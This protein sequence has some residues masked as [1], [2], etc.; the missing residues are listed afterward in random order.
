MIELVFATLQDDS[1]SFPVREH[2]IIGKHVC[3]VGAEACTIRVVDMAIGDD[4]AIIVAVSHGG[5]DLY[6][7]GATHDEGMIDP[8]ARAFRG[9]IY[10]SPLVIYMFV[11]ALI[12]FP[13]LSIINPLVGQC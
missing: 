11:R 9:Y 2:G 1:P 3:A 4:Q 10:T 12:T 8:V 5:V 13:K 7:E 6:A